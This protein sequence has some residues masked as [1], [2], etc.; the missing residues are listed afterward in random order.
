MKTNGKTSTVKI[1]TIL[2]VIM[3]MMDTV[4]TAT[5]IQW[6]NIK[7]MLNLKKILDLNLIVLLLH[8][9]LH[10]HHQVL[11]APLVLQVL[12]VP[13]ALQ[14]HLAHQ[15]LLVH[16]VHQAH[17]ALLALL[18]HPAQAHPVHL[19]HPALV[20]PVHPALVHPVQAHLAHLAQVVLVL[21]V[22]Q[23]MNLTLISHHVVV[24]IVIIIVDS[25]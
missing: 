17:Q 23:K 25:V 6:M 22:N 4:F 5:D 1:M 24:I 11:Q 7:L 13:L 16:L 15:A 8:P 10:P 21:Q 14:V 19:V 9:P 18:V 12:V 20:H 3:K 2:E